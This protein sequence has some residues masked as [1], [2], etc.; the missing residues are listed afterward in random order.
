VSL[1]DLAVLGAA[2]DDPQGFV[3]GLEGPVILDEVQRTPELF[4]AIKAEVDR[5]RTPGRFLLTGSANVLL[6]PG[7]AQELAGRMEV[8]T[9]YPLSQG[10]I[11]GRRDGFLDALFRPGP[12]RELAA[13]GAREEHWTRMLRGGFPEPVKRRDPERRDA[14]LESYVTTVLSREVRDLARIEGLT[15]LPDLLRLLAVRTGTLLNVAELSRAAGLP[16]TTLKRYLALLE[17][18]FLLRR[19]PAWSPNLR[20]RLVKSPKAFLP[21]TGLSSH[22]LGM[23]PADPGSRPQ[24]RG[25]LLESFV[26]WE[27]AKQASWSRLRPRLYHFR[28]HSGAEV[29]L[30]LET[31]DGR[32]V[33]IETKSSGRVSRSDSRGL[34][35]MA[36][37]LGDRFVRGVL[38]Y[39]GGRAVPLGEKLVALPISALW[40]M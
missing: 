34:R 21:D 19:L 12:I 2:K 11:D 3:A 28:T 7:L 8:H 27:V 14:W 13:I 36:S 16:H 30:V 17:A 23:D 6:L 18:A 32:T 4:V 1:D 31:A 24:L 10:E 15:R 22:L 33:G 20:K 37:E 9:L 5:E 29:D 25:P 40:R 35:L 38:M 39:G 26:H